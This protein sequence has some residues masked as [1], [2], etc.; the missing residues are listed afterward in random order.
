MTWMR[1]TDGVWATAPL[2]VLTVFVRR[3][4]RL[5]LLLA[6]VG[7]LAAGAAEWIA[8]AYAGSYGGLAHRLAEGSRIQ[9][10]LGWHTAIGDQ[11]R[12]LGGRTL[13][14][15]CTGPMPNPAVTLWWF[16]LPLLAVS[17]AVV[18]LRARR[19]ASP[20]RTLVPLAC[21]ATAAFP[22]LFM[23]GYAAPRFLLPAY[24]LLALPV[25]DVLWHLVKGRDCRWRTVTATLVA[26]GLAGHLAV[27]YAVLHRTVA[28]TT[29]DR[30]GWSRTADALHRLGVRP[31]CLLTGD[32]SVPIA[33]YAGCSSAATSG[34]NANS[35]AAG[36]ASAAQH[37]PV[38]HLA[39]PGGHPP[40]YTRGWTAHTIGGVR[41]LVA[42]TAVGGGR[43]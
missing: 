40:S 15:P 25:A 26:I 34:S 3:W 36:I 18:A 21:A 20:S 31:P 14:R 43:G 41:V 19:P 1:P 39:T 30:H 10:G 29:A 11:L 24:A 4:R 32:E 2:L 17:A 42:P 37:M 23:I 27:Q 13:C 38:A 12:S 33:F 22:Y 6:L 16:V 7:G 8:E 35:T 28:R 5:P 9:G